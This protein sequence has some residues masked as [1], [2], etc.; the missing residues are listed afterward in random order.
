DSRDRGFF[1][2]FNP[3]VSGPIV[4]DKLWFFVNLEGRREQY[5]DPADPVGLLPR[6]PDRIYGSLRGSS[7]LTW[8]VSPRHKLVSF[9][10]FNV[11]SN[12]NQIRSYAP[13]TEADAQQTTT[14]KDWMT[15]LIWEA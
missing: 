12:A 2:M 11:R 10:N 3:N 6:N 8:Q 7:K 13:A 4:K 1:Y 5:V 9:T 15:G 14:D